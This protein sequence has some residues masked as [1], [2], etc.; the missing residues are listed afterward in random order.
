VLPP[1]EDANLSNVVNN[2]VYT[3]AAAKKNIEL[4]ITVAKKAGDRIP[5]EWLEV[6]DK[7]Y[8]PF[9]EKNDRFLEYDGYNGHQ[10]KQADTELLIYPLMYPMSEDIKINTFDFYKTKTNP[11]GPAMTSSIHAII[12]AELNRPDE[13]YQHFIESY[14]DFLRGPFLMFNEKRSKTY[15]NMCFVT[16]CGGTLQ[17]V[18]FGFAGLRI[19]KDP[20]GFK[21]VL[22][23]LYIK[24]CL[25]PKWKKLELNNIQWQGKAYDLTILTGN[26]WELKRR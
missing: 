8:I 7:M 23:G 15:E 18:I 2:S 22:P 4:A 26:K 1:D 12:A 9:D 11:K 19:G 14:K 20:G 6:A 3:N 5:S 17:S 16:G 10:A 21:E 24:P 25:P 13:A